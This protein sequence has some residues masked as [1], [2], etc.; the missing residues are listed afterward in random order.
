MSH[1]TPQERLIKLNKFQEEVIDIVETHDFNGGL[2]IATG[3]GKSWILFK[4]LV[5]ALAVK[6]LKVGDEVWIMAEEVRARRRTLF[7]K[8]LPEFQKTVG[9]DLLKSLDI[10]FYSYNIG[11]KKYE[12]FLKGDIKAPKMILQDE[13]EAGQ[14][15]KFHKTL[16]FKNSGVSI[17]GLSATDGATM[18][19]FR[20]DKTYDEIGYQ[21]EALTKKKVISKAINKG[22]ISQMYLPVICERDLEWGISE[23]L[24]SPFETIVVE[25]SLSDKVQVNITKKWKGSEKRFWKFWIGKAFQKETSVNFKTTI[26]QQILPRF[27]YK[28]E[29]KQNVLKGIVKRLESKNYK[30]LV[31]APYL[32]WLEEVVPVAT[33]K[34]VNDYL[35]KLDKGEILTLGSS[36]R[37][38]RGVSVEGLNALVLCLFG[39]SNTTATQILG[40]LV[41]YGHNKKGKLII[42]VTDKTYEKRWFESIQKVKNYK[43]KVVKTYNLNIV[44]TVPSLLFTKGENS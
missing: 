27:L 14:S 1:L 44:K 5:R 6:K 2:L 13:F 29:S 10:K 12:S 19:V 11:P 38:Q 21:P 37:L 33:E 32:D 8:E 18:K 30:T 23:G 4:I 9:L 20:E 7:D 34:N 31:F 15:A 16:L 3:L 22:Q 28:L 41:R 39:K 17:I 35:D 42:I 26:L 43:G 40:R 25:H 24:L 36:K